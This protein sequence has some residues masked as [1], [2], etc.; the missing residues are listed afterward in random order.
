MANRAI[1]DDLRMRALDL[2]RRKGSMSNSSI[3]LHLSVDEKTIRR[4]FCEKLVELLQRE[5]EE[6][7]RR[8]EAKK[9]IQVA[10]ENL[11][12]VDSQFCR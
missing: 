6:T 11:I 12:W 8:I 2:K 5:Y 1:D 9:R 3:A 10:R 4:W 7:Q